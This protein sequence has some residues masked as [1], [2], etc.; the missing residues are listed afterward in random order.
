[1]DELIAEIKTKFI[2]IIESYK[3]KPNTRASR[4]SFAQ[5]VGMLFDCYGLE[6]V[7]FSLGE[8]KHNPEIA[9]IKPCGLK[10]HIVF[11]GILS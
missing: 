8:D 2:T 1:M 9:T 7:Q 3:Y 4:E 6:D 5:E 11:K 10:D